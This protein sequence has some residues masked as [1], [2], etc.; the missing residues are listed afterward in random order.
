MDVANRLLPAA[1][2]GVQPA[3]P[4]RSTGAHPEVVTVPRGNLVGAAAVRVADAHQLDASH[5]GQQPRMMLA[6][7]ADADHRYADWH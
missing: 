7:M 5:R 1:A 6:E 4:V 2:P 3:R